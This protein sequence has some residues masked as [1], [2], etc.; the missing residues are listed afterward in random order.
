MLLVLKMLKNDEIPKSNNLTIVLSFLPSSL[1]TLSV[2]ESDVDSFF[3]S[4]ASASESEGPKQDIFLNWLFIFR[5]TNYI[6]KFYFNFLQ[7]QF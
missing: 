1:K 7:I 3:A 4:L 6:I 2:L 5:R